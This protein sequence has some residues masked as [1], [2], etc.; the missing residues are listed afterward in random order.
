MRPVVGVVGLV[1]FVVLGCSGGPISS[2]SPAIN[3]LGIISPLIGLAWPS[4]STLLASRV[5]P[6]TDPERREL[7]SI[8]IGNAQVRSVEVARPSECPSIDVLLPRLSFNGIAFDLYCYPGPNTPI[9]GYHE[10][11]ASP[12]I[13]GPAGPVARVPWLPD[14]FV[15]VAG[16]AWLAGYDDGLCAWIDLV[17]GTGRPQFE[18]PITVTDDGPPFAVSAANSAGSCD[19]SPMASEITL[20]QD[21]SIAFLASGASRGT[22]GFSRLDVARNVYLR[23]SNGMV[24][25]LGEGLQRSRDLSWNATGTK[26]AVSSTI[27]GR[28][29]IWTFDRLGTR[30]LVYEGSVLSLA[31]SPD[32]D[33]LAILVP[34]GPANEPSS[35][36]QLLLVT[37]QP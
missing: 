37:P 5:I 13:D 18:W 15:Q 11:M 21:G 7:V 19:G 31:W 22:S 33:R 3:D 2:P 28:T 14:S 9:A 35:L 29:G 8:S 26:L 16:G 24:R 25:R 10:I 6:N 1:A 27:A 20:A 17:P 32:G 12:T 34:R 30:R 4:G 36:G 23:D